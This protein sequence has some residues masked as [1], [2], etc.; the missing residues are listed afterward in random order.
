MKIAISS[1]G[2]DLESQVG[3][4]FGRSQYFIIVDPAIRAFEVVN[5]EAAA[6]SGGASI[7]AA[8][9]VVNAGADTVVTGSLGPNSTNALMAAGL[10][11]YLGASGTVRESLEQLKEGRLHEASKP[12]TDMQASGI[13]GADGRGMGLGMGLGRRQECGGGSRID[14]IGDCVC[15]ACGAR[16]PHQPGD[17]CFGQ[18]CPKCGAGTRRI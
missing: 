16:V 18:R 13:G 10:K 6:L 8:Q 3:P 5:N 15:P 17:P 14:P 12:A 11:V 1:K 9:T 4:R 2:T 7:Q